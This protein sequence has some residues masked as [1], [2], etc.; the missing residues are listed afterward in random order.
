MT[1]GLALAAGASSAAAFLA[2]NSYAGALAAA[3]APP[4]EALLSA[5]ASLP[6]RFAEGAALSADPLPM[7]AGLACACAPWIA[8][9][10]HLMREG[11]YRRGEEHGSS[12]WGTVREGRRFADGKD[13]DN[14]VILTQ[15]YALRLVDRSFDLASDRNKNIMVLGG[16]GSGKTRHF[17]KPALMALNASYF[18]TDPKGTLV[19]ETGWMFKEAGY[20]IAAFNTIDF[21][22]SLRYNPLSY[23]ETE[24][25]ILV[26]VECLIKNTSGDKEHSGDPFWENAERLLYTALVAYL[27]FHCPKRDRNVPGL[28]R[29]LSLADA[30]E[31][32]ESYLSPLDLLFNELETGMRA[33]ARPRRARSDPRD[34]SGAAGAS[35]V[36]WVRIDE[37][38]DPEE[39]FALSNYRAFKA[40][41]GKTLKSI[42]ISCNVR[43][44]PLSVKEVSRLLE[45]DEMHLDRLGDAGRRT[46]VFASMS[47][48]ESTF[49]FLFAILMWQTMSVLFRRALDAY[50]GRL[51]TPVHFVLDEFANLGR[52]PD[53]DRMMATARSRNVSFS[54]ILQSVSQLEKGYGKEGAKTIMDCCDTTLFL[55]GKS[56]E[57]NEMVSKMVGKQTV[58]TETTS[59]ARGASRTTT[60]NYGLIERALMTPDEVGRLP[61]DEAI[62]LITGAF[63]LRD[64]KYDVTGHPRY[65]LIDPG[66][67]EGARYDR[68]F[69]FGEEVVS[70]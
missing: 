69:D 7:A 56:T 65:P 60:S 62:V 27:V 32:D 5:A 38:V 51:P 18:V 39:D 9:A 50:G 36:D 24:A 42:I 22:R 40:A 30:R 23:V 25:D 21:S 33:V 41:A 28:L 59:D 1:R 14:N 54:V 49:S 16:P 64:K 3:Q 61:R 37:P 45:F 15:S 35:G 68:P 53:F 63:P 19:G 55:G 43:T 4:D 34:I 58:R 17:C 52:V 20:R 66:P 12:R 6:A 57:T 26:F 47:D 70:P 2:A 48:T 11:A 46:V 29:L 67:R 13:P 10:R 8:Y 31:E 44:K